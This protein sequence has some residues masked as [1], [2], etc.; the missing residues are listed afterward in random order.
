MAFNWHEVWERKG[1]LETTNL[2]ELDGFEETTIDPEW[3]AKQI[4]D[5][6]EI[7][8]DDKVLE[9]GCG[10]GMIA[11]YLNCDYVGIDYSKSLVQKHIQL[12]GH[13]VLQGS[14]NNLIFK[15][16]SFDKVFAYSVFHYFPDLDYAKTV[17]REMKR[18][19]KTAIFIG[20]LPCKSHRAEH[21]LFNA[22]DFNDA[23]TTPG[24]YNP[25][26]F[27]ILIKNKLS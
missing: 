3:V 12:L 8:P 25:D 23:E 1:R 26:R 21:L 11:Q 22:E 14:A 2:K 17:I 27:N 5:I 15:D 6:L 9:V 13:S 16:Q 4:S 18:V 24:F 7:K 20:D 10:A 19:A